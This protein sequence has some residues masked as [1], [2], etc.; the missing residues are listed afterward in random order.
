[1]QKRYVSSS[2]ADNEGDY[3][4]SRQAQPNI[5]QETASIAERTLSL[6]T[7]ADELP[8]LTNSDNRLQDL[9]EDG[10]G[11]LTPFARQ[12]SPRCRYEQPSNIGSDEPAA[13]PSRV[14]G[15]TGFIHE[16]YWRQGYCEQ[17]LG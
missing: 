6:L 16:N 11:R 12:V 17:C 4:D 1:M 10:D 8:I 15:L 13:T 9:A 2:I 3:G 5:A 14:Q 7:V